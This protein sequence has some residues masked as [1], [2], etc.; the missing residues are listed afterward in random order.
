MS[1][2]SLTFPDGAKRAVPAGTTGLDVAKSIAPSLAKRSV[3]MSLNGKLADL[4]AAHQGRRRDQIPHARGQGGA[5]A[6]PPRRRACD[7]AGRAGALSRHAGDHRP[8][9]RQRLLLRLRARASRSRPRTC[10]RSKPRCARSSP[11]TRRSH[12]RSSTARRAKKLFAEQGRELQGRDHR[13]DS[14]RRGDHAL[15]AGRVAR[16]LPRPA[17]AL[18]RQG[19]QG[20]QADEDRRRLLA[21]RFDATRCSSA[22]TARRGPD[23]KELKAYLHRLEE[24]EKRD[25]RRLGREMDLF[26]FQ[27]EAPGAVFWH[28]KGWA[29]FQR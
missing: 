2:I 17:R 20:L 19:R 28:P 26:H 10:R 11:A 16:P 25:H 29:L 14:R 18:D 12:A 1:Q 8:G 15:R 3:A 24:A 9:D 6:D 5:R 22:S 4:A 21:R 13:R 27:E 7:G 23:E